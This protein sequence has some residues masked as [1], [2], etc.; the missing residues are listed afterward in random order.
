MPLIEEFKGQ[1][2]NLASLFYRRAKDYIIPSFRV[3]ATVGFE[4][5]QSYFFLHSEG[6]CYHDISFGNVSVNPL[7]GEILLHDVDH[8]NLS[9]SRSTVISSLD[10]MAP[11]EV[12]REAFPSVYTDLYSL[13]VLLFCIFMR[14]HPLDG[15]NIFSENV[16]DDDEQRYGFQPV[17][18]FDP[19]D[20]SNRPADQSLAT[21]WA[22]YPQFL[23]ERFIHAFTKGLIDPIRGRVREDEWRATFVRL[24]DSIFYCSHCGEQNFY[25]ETLQERREEQHSCWSCKK[26]TLLPPRLIM[27]NHAVMLN[28][29]T[30]LYPHHIDNRRI[31]DFSSSIAEV[32]RHP[33]KPHVWSLKNLSTTQWSYEKADGIYAELD[34]GKSIALAPGTK[35]FFGNMVGEILF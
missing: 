24:R 2:R 21:L 26:N 5:A 3:L 9:G 34:G 28:H 7:S 8:I 20:H 13:S 22:S 25:D 29:D 18:I 27:R 12:R 32:N 17:F 6:L 10:F 23:R 1:Y 30:K 4:L 15:K 16:G 35:L 19:N 11:E 33:A 31:Y 14:H